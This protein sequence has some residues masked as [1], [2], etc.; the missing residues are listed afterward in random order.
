ME[1][2]TPTSWA[3]S[4]GCREYEESWKWGRTVTGWRSEV[5]LWLFEGARIL[6]KTKID[7]IHHKLWTTWK[8]ASNYHKLWAIHSEIEKEMSI[9]TK[10]GNQ[11]GEKKNSGRKRRKFEEFGCP[12]SFP[13]VLRSPLLLFNNFIYLKNF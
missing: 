10:K 12:G 6:R 13:L 8:V 2:P 1:H 3:S 9:I 5:S 4:V 7:Q 11:Q